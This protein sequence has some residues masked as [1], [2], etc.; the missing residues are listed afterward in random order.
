MLT[1]KQMQEIQ[2]CKGLCEQCSI[3]GLRKD[4]PCFDFIV[5]ELIEAREVTRE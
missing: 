5:N 1:D 2:D 4:K 3:K